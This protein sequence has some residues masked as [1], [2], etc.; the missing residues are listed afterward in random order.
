MKTLSIN[1]IFAAFLIFGNIYTSIAQTAEQLYQKGLMQEE[2]EG[3]LPEAINIFN[4]IV[5]NQSADKSIQAK[6]LLHVGLCYEKLGKEEATKAYQKL[7]NN[8]PGQKGEVAIAREKLNRL[9]IANKK[10]AGNKGKEILKKT[11][12][13][14]KI[15]D[16]HNTDLEGAVSPDGRYLS[17]V[18]WDTGDLA[19]YEIATGEKRRLTDKG[20]WEKNSAYCEYSRWFPDSKKIIYLW[21]NE[22]QFAELRTISLD[23]SEPEILIKDKEMEWI[24]IYNCSSD[25][26]YILACLDRKNNDGIFTLISANDGSEQA[27]KPFYTSN[28]AFSPDGRFV[29][30]DHAQKGDKGNRDIYILELDT[31]KESKLI[32]HPGD[33]RLLGRVPNEN[34]ILF[35]SDRTGTPDFW[36]V[37]VENGKTLGEPSLIKS[38]R[39]PFAPVSLGFTDSGAFYY[40]QRINN[41]N[42]YETEIEP[43]TGEI[44]T[45]PT[46]IIESYIGANGC[47]DYSP[48]GKYLAYVSRRP[49]GTMRFTTNP[50]GNVLR[51]RSLDTEEEREFRPNINVFGFPRWSPDGRS[52]MV[53]NWNVNGDMGLYQIDTQTGNATPVI[54]TKGRGLFGGHGWSPDGNTFYYGR[55]YQETMSNQIVARNMTSGKEKVVYQSNHHFSISLSS[56]GKLLALMS[57]E[58]QCLKVIPT[59]GG[60]S[61]VLISSDE[62]GEI[63]FDVNTV[64]LTWSRNGKYIYFV[65]KE[66]NMDDS[67]TELCRISANDAKLEKLGLKMAGGFVNLSAHLDGKHFSYSSRDKLNSEVWVMENFLPDEKLAQSKA[68]VKEPQ[69]IRIRQISKKPYLDDLGTVTSDGKYLSC[70]DW[71]KGDLAIRDVINGDK[72]LLTDNATLEENPQKFV[73]GT[74]IS[75]NGK[76]LAYSWW[77]PYHTFDLHLFDVENNSSKLL[78]KEE[79]VE[80]YPLAWLSDSKLITIRQYRNNE[81]TQI[82]SLNVLDG[83]EQILKTFDKRIWTQLC[84]SP[85]EKYIAYNTIAKGEGNSN[86]TLLTADGKSEIPLV[87]H[88]ADDKVFGWFPDGNDFLFTSDRSGTWDLWSLP[89]ADGK[90]TGEA[91]RLYTE[92]GEVAPIGITESGDCFFGF[93]KR[94]FNAYITPIDISTGKP[95]E[96]PGIPLDGSIYS[97]TWSPDGKY[98]ACINQGKRSFNLTLKDT[99]NGEEREFGKELLYAIGPHWSRDGKSVFV[100][101]MDKSKIQ[102]NRD[103]G[104]IF[105]IDLNTGKA[106]E[107]LLISNYKYTP[108]DDDA[109]PISG[110]VVSADN[111]SII[112]LFQND[113][114]VKH[115]LTTGLD[116]ILYRNSNFVRGVL[117]LSPDCNKLLFAINN[118]GEERSRLMTMTVEGED[119]RE[120]CVSQDAQISGSAFWSLDGKF[121]YFSERPEGTNLWR[122]KAEGGK[123]EKVWHTDKRAESFAI[124]PFGKEISYTV[125]ERTTEIRVIE[126]LV[127]ECEKIYTQNE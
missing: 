13:N 115:N 97:I 62:E 126:G 14:K 43:I 34:D 101:G 25:G 90:P 30:Y 109:L 6:A 10:I 81:T 127:Q 78:F 123:P 72:Q 51:I 120:L 4:Q 67:E 113:W 65:M 22:G 39:G 112:M 23:N 80:A 75:K 48:D 99:E 85:D 106:S 12:S 27:L 18:D 105:T 40:G 63:D 5:E 82:I 77:R 33:D 122:V 53:V 86:I 36:Q 17:Y 93:S 108:S 15:W 24:E 57:N 20:S 100:F 94:N 47:P 50:V 92:I 38:N 21:Y 37:K 88:P 74:A 60:K 66:S 41:V 118:K 89:I 98:M 91:K 44:I 96:K 28:A 32:E 52:V 124:H 19:V 116:T 79:G 95:E 117:Q 69:G 104:G 110:H 125:R 64:S 59:A 42:I 103:K 61:Q 121:I 70:V 29:I 76:L 9:I 2:G 87:D 68:A 49:P 35:I 11:L 46:R 3:N 45:A 55:H 114:I 1:L 8:F 56:D 58:E 16:E 107:K 119:V 31:K 84:T 73:I 102:E 54:L 83:S 7:V 26:K 111:Q 71:G